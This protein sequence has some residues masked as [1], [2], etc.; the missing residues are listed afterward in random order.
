[1][2][3]IALIPN[4]LLLLTSIKA[5]SSPW[6]QSDGREPIFPM[7]F[8]RYSLDRTSLKMNW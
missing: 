1:M 6:Y 4:R 5:R 8:E 7:I 2:A 3:A